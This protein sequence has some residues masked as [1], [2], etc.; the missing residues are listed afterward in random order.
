MLVHAGAG[1]WNRPV[2]QRSR[3]GIRQD[4]DLMIATTTS[5]TWLL[6]QLARYWHTDR[7][8]FPRANGRKRDSKQ[9]VLK[10]KFVF[11]SDRRTDP[12]GDPGHQTAPTKNRTH[13]GAHTGQSIIEQ[14]HPKKTTTATT[15]RVRP[16]EPR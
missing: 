16:L 14:W 2:T 13:A 5:A 11:I 6:A 4:F 3:T 12:G 7:R 15:M 9:K 10:L 1:A 8:S